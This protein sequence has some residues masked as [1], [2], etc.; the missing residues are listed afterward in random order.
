MAYQFA[1]LELA[2]RMK[3]EA[4]LGQERP[5]LVV[6]GVIVK[7]GRCHSGFGFTTGMILAAA[8]GAAGDFRISIGVI[9]INVPLNIGC[10]APDS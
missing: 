2:S 6:E 5:T 7:G 8:G 9:S 1:K 4:S 3:P 10:H